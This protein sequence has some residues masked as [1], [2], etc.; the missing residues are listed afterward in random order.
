MT[1]R[2]HL[3]GEVGHEVRVVHPPGDE[4][5]HLPHVAAIEL[6]ELLG[7]LPHGVTP[8]L[9]HPYTLYLAG[10]RV[11]VTSRARSSAASPQENGDYEHPQDE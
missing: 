4:A 3:R 11:S 1:A 8:P 2:K 6:L 9:R 10:P 5:A 7:R